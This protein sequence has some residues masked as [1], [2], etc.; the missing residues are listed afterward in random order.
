MSIGSRIKEARK[1]LSISQHKLAELVGVTQ[2][3]ISRWENDDQHPGRQSYER[4]AEALQT[5]PGYLAFGGSINLKSPQPVASVSV[6]GIIEA[7]AFREA[8]SLEG[9]FQRVNFV[10]H[11]AYKADDQVA[12][13][14]RGESCNQVVQSGDH[15]IA[16]PYASFPGG[17][18][19]LLSKPR[20]PLVVVQRERAGLVEAT[21]KELRVRND[22]FELWPRSD[23]P[24]HQ[25]RIE[26][27]ENG[28]TSDVSIT[29]VVIRIVSDYL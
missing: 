23:A 17:L 25:E 19:A 18:E 12:F 11:P 2:T 13:L 8:L 21:L 27:N 28:D 14:V 1:R 5:D 24:E 26:F 7:G 10:P 16:V 15:V 6:L 29:H 22:R 9:E 20:P 3:A 4:L